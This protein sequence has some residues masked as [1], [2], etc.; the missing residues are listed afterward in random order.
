M[1]EVIGN[2]FVDYYSKH[3]ISPV[4]QDISDFD[5]HIKR[6]ENLFITLGIPPLVFKGRRILEIGPGSG[7]NALVYFHWGANIDFV[8][9]NPKAQKELNDLLKAHSIDE[10]R[11]NLFKT[12]IEDSHINNKY[13]I[14]IAEGFIPGL[15]NQN[16][17]LE[18]VKN[19]VAKSGILV[20][21]CMDDISVFF[22]ILKRYIG[23]VLIYRKKIVNFNE[24]INL[25]SI[26]F[27][28]HLNSLNNSSRI[29]EDWILDQFF[30]PS[31]KGSFFSIEECI[32][33]FEDF[34][35]MN[36]SPRMFTDYS[37]YKDLIYDKKTSIKTQFRSKHHILISHELND[38]FKDVVFNQVLFE[39]TNLFRKLVSDNENNI[40][41]NNILEIIHCLNEIKSLCEEIDEKIVQA[42][43]E[44]IELLSNN[45]LNEGHFV[46]KLAFTR[47]FGKGQQYISLVKNS[48]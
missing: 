34:I 4:R 26:V 6:R 22:E 14:V 45:N 18:K 27:A 41:E 37:W 25:L 19:L 17:V 31:L 29:L 46:E 24:K 8:E 11:W 7:H 44:S 9:P 23:K 2:P 43:N 39:K 1:S 13:E 21:T 38:S 16:E 15:F 5:K 20:L 28:A 10:R 48:I 35:F 36:S 3:N 42:I 30:T 40:S 32:D 12:M 33:K 47:A